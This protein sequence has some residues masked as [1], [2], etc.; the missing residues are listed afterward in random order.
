ML[1][2]F[3]LGLLGVLFSQNRLYVCIQIIYINILVWFIRHLLI[4]CSSA[5]D[6]SQTFFRLTGKYCC[7]ST[8]TQNPA[9]FVVRALMFQLMSDL[10]FPVN[11][12]CIILKDLV[13]EVKYSEF[14]SEKICMLLVLRYQNHASVLSILC[15]SSESLIIIQTQSFS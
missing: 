9:D 8:V 11:I 5:T 12:K 2:N 6:R 10:I 13:E 7:S 3:Y 4:T 14:L 15:L 1:S